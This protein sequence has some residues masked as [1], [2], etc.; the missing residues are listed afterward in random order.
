MAMTSS[1]QQSIPGTLS[2]TCPTYVHLIVQLEDHWAAVQ[3]SLCPFVIQDISGQTFYRCHYRY[4]LCCSSIDEEDGSLHS[5]VEKTVQTIYDVYYQPLWWN[6]SDQQSWTK[7]TQR[8]GNHDANFSCAKVTELQLL[9]YINS[10]TKAINDNIVSIHIS[11]TE[12]TA[13][14]APKRPREHYI[15]DSITEENVYKRGK[16]R[17]RGTTR[18]SGQEIA[19]V[20]SSNDVRV[21]GR[22]SVASEE[23]LC[24]K[25]SKNIVKKIRHGLKSQK[26]DR[27]VNT[28]FIEDFS[29]EQ[30]KDPFEYF[31][32][33]L[34]LQSSK[35][36]DTANKTA[37]KYRFLACC[38]HLCR[39]GQVVSSERKVPFVGTNLLTVHR[40]RCAANIIN[41]IVNGLTEAWGEKA[42]LVY[43]ALAEKN[44][45]LTECS[46][47]SERKRHEVVGIV[48]KILSQEEVPATDFQCPRFHPAFCISTVLNKDYVEVCHALDL[49]YYA[50]RGLLI[51]KENL[52]RL[53]WEPMNQ[54]AIT[55]TI[56]DS[57]LQ[58][59]RPNNSDRSDA[60]SQQAISTHDPINIRS[61]SHSPLLSVCTHEDAGQQEYSSRYPNFPHEQQIVP[62]EGSLIL[63]RNEL[64]PA[65][66]L[67]PG[68]RG[69]VQSILPESSEA[70]Q[71]NPYNTMISQDSA[72][73]D[74]PAIQQNHPKESEQLKNGIVNSA[75]DGC[76]REFSIPLLS[77]EQQASQ[78]SA[79]PGTKLLCFKETQSDI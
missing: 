51:T 24:Q 62:H 72:F 45:I 63:A 16:H 70:E 68:G 41:M 46:K 1:T 43:E 23:M 66:Q 27:G 74:Q 32:S 21:C 42:D 40:W 50:R 75:L 12:I 2:K 33:Q 39:A 53:P 20:E 65:P 38:I 61:T 5:F 4:T 15:D 17:R 35:F 37:W 8:P 6:F 73:D 76:Q 26:G 30:Y 47:L 18:S 44:C 49:G 78:L 55:S 52:F 59:I 60:D 54:I 36:I 11:A 13:T 25:I 28:R 19:D 34:W 71:L 29:I 14:P 69:Q 9:N 67:S 10:A 57:I 3:I 22:G 31:E 56:P 48:V 79:E 7:E 77:T 64:H 58:E